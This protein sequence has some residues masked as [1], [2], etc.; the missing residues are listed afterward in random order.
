MPSNVVTAIR[1]D[2]EGFLWMATGAG[3]VRF[4]GIRFEVFTDKDGLPNTQITSLH[5][6]RRGRIW[7]GTRRGVA[8]RE[9]G[10]W[11]VPKGLPI[12]PI[13]SLG[14]GADGSIWL[15]AYNGCWRWKG[16]EVSHIKLESGEQDTRAFLADEGGGMWILS[17]SDLHRWR[18]ESSDQAQPHPG[19]WT[20]S[21][22]RS[23]TRDGKGSLIICGTGVLWRQNGEAWEDLSETMPGGKE[24]AN[25]ACAWAPDGTLWLATR[26]RGLV[27]KD[28]SGWGSVDPTKG[29]SLDDARALLIDP[30]G[31]IWAGT[32]GGGINRLRHRLFDTYSSRD[33]LGRTVTSALVEDGEGSV[34][35]GTDGSGVFLKKDGRFTPAP[36]ELN[37][38]G[39]G[40]IWSMCATEDG[41]LWIGTYKSGLLRLR[42][43]EVERIDIS[44]KV[45]R[46]TISALRE[47]REGELLI[48]THYEGVLKWTDGKIAPVFV[49][50]G[51]RDA[52]VHAIMQSRVGDLWVAAGAAGLWRRQDGTWKKLNT[53]LGMPGLIATALLEGLNGD[54]WIGS[55]GQGLVRYRE[56][57]LM[58]W[59]RA[60]GLI[61]ETIVQILEDEFGNLWLGS[62]SG[63]QRVSPS[64]LPSERGGRS[65][66]IRSLRISREDALPTPQ[67]SGEHGNLATRTEDGS[68]WFSLASGVIRIQPRN[69]AEPPPLPS[70]FIQSASADKGELWNSEV[71]RGGDNIVLEPGAGTLQ[72]RFTSP[73]FVAP[74]KLRFKYRMAGLES[75][76]QE[77]TGS[78][79]ANYAALPPGSY[80][81]EVVG[82]RNDGVWNP[83]AAL[84]GVIVKPYFWQT[85][86]FRMAM[87][88]ISVSVLALLVRAWSLRRIRRRLALLVQEQR[89]D[90]ERARIARDLHDELGASL[91]EI[92][93]LGTLAAKDVAESPARQKLDVIV[94]R[95]QS[96]AKSLDEIVWTVN[97]AND[98][99][100]STAN[101]LSSRAQESLRAANIRCRLE[102]ANDLPNVTLDS[103][104][105]HH[106]LM[107]VN[108]AVN[109]VRKHSGTSDSLLSLGME[110]EN[111][112][113]CV[114]DQG[115]GFDPKAIAEGRNGFNNM[116]RRLEAAGGRC[117]IESTPEKGTRV[118]LVVPL[119]LSSKRT[120]S[121]DQ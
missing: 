70:V 68:L 98:T 64:T 111:L 99:L 57:Q 7:A 77:S 51:V 90:K 92:N 67:F 113:V 43:G 116:R 76:W 33:G 58:A 10:V 35:V 66:P 60:E 18:P 26:N 42:D 84:V 93:F 34:W 37:L 36:Y 83:K 120:A 16:G 4:D 107:A 87:A 15:G 11:T 82:A 54:I 96:M 56:G 17:Q 41:S 46:N 8:Y 50:P 65:A 14:E 104:L 53:E 52:P 12:E 105:R 62:D 108:E 47:T 2:A 61:S 74:E 88:V 55:L 49:V 100:S 109:N 78:R 28:E 95:A 38:P 23:I 91:S 101:Y 45:P 106:L 86:G 29:L 97:P 75:E 32:N 69:F 20:G 63:L 44:N 1:R 21:D 27:Y 85:L 117:E 118:R 30:E 22:L 6:D 79:T 115:H 114:Q 112:I 102:V 110:Q 39:E 13:F 72:I 81:F 31:T 89:V 103:E 94:E 121:S 80:Q 48:G 25:L 119:L 9:N 3:V 40:L 59:S 24:S 5:I 19:P 71:R 73:G